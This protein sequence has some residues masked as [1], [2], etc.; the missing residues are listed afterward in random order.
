MIRTGHAWVA[1]DFLS[2][3]FASISNPCLWLWHACANA[4]SSGTPTKLMPVHNPHLCPT[5][6]RVMPPSHVG[7]S[8]ATAARR[9]RT[10]GQAGSDLPIREVTKLCSASHH[11]LRDSVGS[12]LAYY[13]RRQ[14]ASCPPLLVVATHDAGPLSD[15]DQRCFLRF[16]FSS[17]D[18]LCRRLRNAYSQLTSARPADTCAVGSPSR[19]VIAAA[20]VAA[21]WY[22]SSRAHARDLL[23]GE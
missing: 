6:T 19:T 20:L 9:R 7:T 5:I 22:C 2:L 4:S 8:Y 23:M 11:H 13:C 21:L 18:L 17:K 3:S 15:H 16:A 14:C 10:P 1:T 12:L